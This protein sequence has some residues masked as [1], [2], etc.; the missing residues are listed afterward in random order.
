[1]SE[2]PMMLEWRDVDA[3]GL[4]LHTWWSRHPG[5]LNGPTYLIQPT[6]FTRQL[7]QPDGSWLTVFAETS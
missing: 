1:M 7:R 6:N 2:S 4:V 5:P 3:D